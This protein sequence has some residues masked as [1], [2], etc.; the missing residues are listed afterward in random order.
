[1]RYAL[2]D[3]AG[4]RITRL[5]QYFSKFKLDQMG[6]GEP[7]AR[8][9]QDHMLDRAR[10]QVNPDGSPWARNAE[11][12]V[13]RKGRDDPGYDTGAMLDESNFRAEPTITMNTITCRYGG[14][15]EDVAKL[16]YFQGDNRYG[17]Q[18]VVWGF[19]DAMKSRVGE[20]LREAWGG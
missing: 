7:I 9:M 12:T 19:D 6:R 20:M 11:S 4:A 17:I 13:R 3:N 18:R 10:R 15:P 14:G 16:N 8:A 5:E 1:M 2:R